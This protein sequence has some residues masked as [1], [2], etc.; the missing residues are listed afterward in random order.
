MIAMDPNK[1]WN[2]VRLTQSAWFKGLETH[3]DA[4]L[5]ADGAVELKS[6]ST[7]KSDS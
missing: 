2:A 3:N 5:R 7:S 4:E 6:E 1:R